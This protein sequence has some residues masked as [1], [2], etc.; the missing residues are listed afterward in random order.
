ME[1]LST[2]LWLD[3]IRG[4][5]NAIDHRKALSIYLFAPKPQDLTDP[6]RDLHVTQVKMWNFAKPLFWSNVR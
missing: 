4:T 2:A 6:G 3:K 5:E 1:F